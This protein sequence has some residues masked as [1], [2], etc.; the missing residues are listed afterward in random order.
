MEK[1]FAFH[2]QLRYERE[3]RGWSQADVAEKVGCDAKTVG[4]WEN[5][6]RFPR[7][8]HRQALCQLFGKNAEEL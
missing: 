8:H 2:E 6:E 1:R 7:P 3:R 5:G 4:R